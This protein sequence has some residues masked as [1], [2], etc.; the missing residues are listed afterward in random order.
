[1]N[2]V[3]CRLSALGRLRSAV[4]RLWFF[5]VFSAVFPASQFFSRNSSNAWNSRQRRA[6]VLCFFSFLV[7]SAFSVVY[8][9]YIYLR[10]SAV[11]RFV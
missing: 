1:M 6:G 9:L 3:G 7:D 5:S 11:Y 2:E 10:L 4:S 8:F